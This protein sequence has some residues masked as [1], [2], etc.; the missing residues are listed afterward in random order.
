MGV[1]Y[2][3]NS[4]LGMSMM[5]A[6]MPFV[7]L[8]RIV[9]YR[10]QVG[11]GVQIVL[12]VVGP[13]PARVHVCV[14]R[15]PQSMCPHASIPPLPCLLF[16]ITDPQASSTYNPWAFG[17]VMSLVEL[18]YILA[19]C[20]MFVCIMY[21]MVDF[22]TEADSFFFYYL[23]TFLSIVFYASFGMV[24]VAKGVL[25]NVMGVVRRQRGF[26]CECLINKLKSTI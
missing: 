12:F 4:F 15:Q 20:V 16:P 9:Y 23:I 25:S 7:G 13:V 3:S 14:N 8:E 18:P 1:I 17:I 21:P 11:Q 19:Q 26:V 24:R 10:E 5:M 2:S 22:R 6:A